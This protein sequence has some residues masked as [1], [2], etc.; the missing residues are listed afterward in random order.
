MACVFILFL[1]IVEEVREEP[2]THC[3]VEETQVTPH[4]EYHEHVETV[5]KPAYD[6]VD[7]QEQKNEQDI[8]TIRYE[9]QEVVNEQAQSGSKNNEE[10]LEM[11]VKKK[12]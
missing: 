6:Y 10:R 11:Y 2:E 1:V 9:V 12:K 3:Y 4:E 5:K 8:V 7:H